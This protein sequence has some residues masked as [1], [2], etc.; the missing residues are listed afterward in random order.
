MTN[1]SSSSPRRPRRGLLYGAAGAVL[2]VLCVNF[3]GSLLVVRMLGT[4][5]A[6]M[7]AATPYSLGVRGVS[8]NIFRGLALTGVT[9]HRGQEPLF[10]AGRIDVGFEGLSYVRR[11]LRI[12][13]VRITTLKLVTARFTEVLEVGRRLSEWQMPLAF[14]D[15]FRFSCRDVH[16]DNMVHL[17]LSGYLNA[18]N[19]ELYT[20][21]G[22]LTLLK[23]RYAAFPEFDV[24]EGSDASWVFLDAAVVH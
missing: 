8:F 7:A 16:F 20:L 13:N 10:D 24:F 2:V 9:I 22:R 12:K 23:I 11:P 6:Q 5:R 17:N 1:S 21:R 15:T 14:Y 19:S 3:A 4:A 18:V